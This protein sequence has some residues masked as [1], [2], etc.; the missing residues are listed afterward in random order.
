MGTTSPLGPVAGE[1]P[2]YRE[3]RVLNKR[4]L[5]RLSDDQVMV[6]RS[7]PFGN[8]FEIGRD[9]DREAVIEKFRRW[10]M[11]KAQADLRERAKKELA[12]KD[13][14][15]WCAPLACHADTWLEIV[16]E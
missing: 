13:L 5:F 4:T 11:R 16:N 9:G 3:P 8:P 12:G 7:T 10:V 15:C 2:L 6:D 1:H 14:V